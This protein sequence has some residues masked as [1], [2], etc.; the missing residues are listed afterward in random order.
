MHLLVQHNKELNVISVLL[1]SSR[2]RATT[3]SPQHQMRFSKAAETHHCFS[4]VTALP[5]ATCQ[6]AVLLQIQQAMTS[7]YA[8]PTSCPLLRSFEIQHITTHLQQQGDGTC[9][10]FGNSLRCESRTRP[11]GAT[12]CFVVYLSASSDTVRTLTNSS[13]AANYTIQGLRY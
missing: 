9:M 1:Y 7:P 8:L 12:E 5:V 10:L 13:P 3:P 2:T 6:Y 4:I 11:P